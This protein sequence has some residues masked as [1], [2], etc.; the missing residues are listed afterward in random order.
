[1]IGTEIGVSISP[2]FTKTNH[3]VNALWPCVHKKLTLLILTDNEYHCI[4]LAVFLFEC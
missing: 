4:I 1:M 3:G 2:F